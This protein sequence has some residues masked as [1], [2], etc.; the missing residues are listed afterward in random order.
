MNEKILSNKKMIDDQKS[1]R[2]RTTTNSSSIQQQKWDKP[3]FK[4][5]GIEQTQGNLGNGADGGGPTT[6]LS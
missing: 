4:T 3:T 6:T 5:L 1:D 2:N